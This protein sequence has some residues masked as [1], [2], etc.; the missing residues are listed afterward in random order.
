MA[1]CGYYTTYL[2]FAFLE[3]TNR[4]QESVI[5]S[6]KIITFATFDTNATSDTNATNATNT[7]NS[8][9]P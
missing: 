8:V 2:N 5:A 3:D 6:R 9:Y 7:I 1:C 4:K